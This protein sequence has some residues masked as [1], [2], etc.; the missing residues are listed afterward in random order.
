[1][2]AVIMRYWQKL[3]KAVR[4]EQDFQAVK[5]ERNISTFSFMQ[6]SERAL[7]MQYRGG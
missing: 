5:F 1:M 7:E 3:G 2:E 4:N 6:K